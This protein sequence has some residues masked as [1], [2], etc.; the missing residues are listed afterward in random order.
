MTVMLGIVLVDFARVAAAVVSGISR[1]RGPFI[2]I[3]PAVVVPTPRIMRETD[4][5]KQQCRSD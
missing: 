1:L 5:W 3:A 4:R 2:T